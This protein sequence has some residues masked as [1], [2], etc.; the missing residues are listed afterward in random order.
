[1]EG[2]AVDIGQFLSDKIELRPPTY[3]KSWTGKQL[4]ERLLGY[5][6]SELGGLTYSDCWEENDRF[7]LRFNGEIGGKAISGVDIV[8]LDADRKIALVEIF[9][10]PPS[11]VLVLRERMGVRVAND[12]IVSRLMGLS[13]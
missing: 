8:E 11:A 3:D 7:V 5:A 2:E 13:K 9:A 12:D 4:V 6:A 1:M 10:R